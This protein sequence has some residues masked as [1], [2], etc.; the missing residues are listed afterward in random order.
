MTLAELNAGDRAGFVAALGDVFEHSPWVAERAWAARPFAGIDALHAA[1][2]AAMHGAGEPLQ[3]ALIRAHPE[4]AGRA[5][6]RAEMTADSTREQ[7]GAGL[8]Q[9]SPDELAQL[10]SLNARYHER[11]GFPFILAVKGLARGAI[12]A[13]FARR[14]ERDRATEFAACLDE[15]AR[16]AGFRL[17]AL[18]TA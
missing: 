17:Q 12:I 9:C 5:M 1:M 10:R 15:I 2:V 11:F 14:V 13:A 6:A 8:A 7:A 4:L 16:I 18:I 3:L